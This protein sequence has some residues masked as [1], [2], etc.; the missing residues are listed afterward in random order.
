MAVTKNT[1]DIVECFIDQVGLPQFL[2]LVAGICADKAE[3]AS[4]NW[5]DADLA[6]RWRQ[7]ARRVE[8]F[9]ENLPS[10]N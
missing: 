8:R 2:E 7:A 6:Y 5:Q 10:P 4:C 1:L 9:A 3:H